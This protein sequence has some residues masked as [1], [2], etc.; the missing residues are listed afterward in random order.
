MKEHKIYPLWPD[1][2][3]PYSEFSPEQDQPSVR[4]FAVPGARSAM[5]IC[6]GGGY[7]CKVDHEKDPIARIYE[8]AGIA[9][10]ILDYRVKP[11]HH[12]APLSDAKRAIRLVR[13]MGYEK[14]G[15]VG[16]S[17]GGHVC[18]SAATLYD[19]GNPE[20]ED[21]I[22]RIS[23]RPDAFVSSYSV[24]S[25]VSF[26]HQGSLKNLLGDMSGDQSL[27]RRFSAELHV[28]GDTPP[29][30]IW[31]SFADGCVPVENSIQLAKAMA[32]AGVPFELHI[33]PGGCHGAG[34]ASPDENAEKWAPMHITWLK[35]LGF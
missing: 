26:P 8:Q 4:E 28:T 25:F 12:E 17:A 24:V 30:F 7:G 27:L 18:C 14:V 11:C 16:F 9:S 31:H 1:Q 29:G 3:A 23:S 6:P 2:V 10:Y 15:I 13:S 34:V 21:P 32:V 19:A 35:S 33:F 22:E 20:A 5:V